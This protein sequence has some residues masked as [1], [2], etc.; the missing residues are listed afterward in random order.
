[1]DKKI[2]L[3]AVGA[4]SNQSSSSE[5][6]QLDPTDLGPGTLESTFPSHGPTGPR[7]QQG[8]DRSKHN[9]LRHGIF[10]KVAVL[11]SESQAEFDR[12]RKDLYADRKPQGALE[13]LLVDKLAVLFWRHRRLVNAEGAEIQMGTEFAQWEKNER[14]RQQIVT[15]PQLTCNGGLI[16][17]IENPE[18]L[19]TSVDLLKDL[20]RSIS[21]NGFCPEYDRG[22]LSKLYGRVDQD[23][24]K[25]AKFKSYEELYDTSNCEEQERK[26]NEYSKPDE[27]KQNFLDDLKNEIRKLMRYRSEHNTISSRKV[28]LEAYRLP[29][30]DR[31]LRY[32]ATLSREFERTLNQLERLQRMRLGQPVPPPINLNVTSSKE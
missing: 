27:F 31:L 11:K 22:I 30:M 3:L 23:G 10:S 17:W 14:Y 29:E 24:L 19:Q 13:Q 25:H 15:L 5:F 4:S 18:A 9:A 2:E 32:E 28:E 21:A 8:K 16:R 6:V 1:M 20:Q 26:E 12:L 7:T